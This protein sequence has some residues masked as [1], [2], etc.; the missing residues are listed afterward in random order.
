MKYQRLTSTE[1]EN[2]KDDF[3][4]FL[5]SNTIT[6]SDWEKIKQDT[7]E[8]AEKLIELYSDIVYEKTFTKCQ[9]MDRLHPREYRVFFFED[10]TAKL[11]VVKVKEGI[12][13]RLKETSLFQDISSGLAK[14]FVELFTA[15]KR[16]KVLR[17]QEMFSIFKQGCRLTDETSYKRLLTLLP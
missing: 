12:D 9:Y 7:P 14:N 3:I 11:I 6:G 16:Y 10:Y 8:K 4:L 1:L 13:F 2:L 5:S 17:E 15:E